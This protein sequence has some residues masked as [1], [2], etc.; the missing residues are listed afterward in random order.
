MST[1]MQNGFALPH[2][3][4]NFVKKLCIVIGLNKKGV[5]FNSID[6]NLSKLF[7][8]I[9]SPK[10]SNNYLN[11]LAEITGFFI[12]VDIQKI[13]SSKT[14]EDFYKNILNTRK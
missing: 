9:I 10:D 13:F 7:I 1:G 6:N 5:D 8:M 2:I 12:N 11:I 3:R 4:T 14:N